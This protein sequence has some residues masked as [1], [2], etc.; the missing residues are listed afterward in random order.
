MNKL[1]INLRE[2]RISQGLTPKK[3]STK[4][5]ITAQYLSR[6][7]NGHQKPSRNT[8]EKMIQAYQVPFEDSEKLR[9]QFGYSTAGSA[10]GS[11]KADVVSDSTSPLLPRFNLSPDASPVYY[12]DVLGVSSDDFGIVI[13]AGQRNALNNEVDIVA[14]IGFSIQHGIKIREALDEHIKKLG[15]GI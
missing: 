15:G 1:D 9:D 5:G 14:R 11:A 7:E 4:L 6:L 13:S 2:I 12:T 3:A 8:L 10:A